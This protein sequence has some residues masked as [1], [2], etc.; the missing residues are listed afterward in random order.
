MK[1]IVLAW[2]PAGRLC[3]QETGENDQA[4]YHTGRLRTQETGDNNG[5]LF[6]HGTLRVG[7]ALS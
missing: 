4:R 7:Y 6:L 1:V 3:T 2:Y 5:G